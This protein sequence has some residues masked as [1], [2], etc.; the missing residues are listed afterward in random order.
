MQTGRQAKIV[1]LKGAFVTRK[2]CLTSDIYSL[3]SIM[4]V[5]VHSKLKHIKRYRQMFYTKYRINNWL[6][7][8]TE[9][10]AKTM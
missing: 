9:C 8:V 4:M 1:K 3:L 7:H 10:K 2:M 6:V 5:I